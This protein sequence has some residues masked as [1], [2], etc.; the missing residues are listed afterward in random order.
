MNFQNLYEKLKR[1]DESDINQG[2]GMMAPP[3]TP[4]IEECGMSEMHGSPSQQDSVNMSVSM[5]ASGKGGIRDLM[6][7]LKNIDD[8]VSGPSDD[9]SDD[10]IIGTPEEEIEPV[11]LGEIPDPSVELDEP[12]QGEEFANEPEFQQ[13]DNIVSG[14]DLHKEKGAYPAAQKGDNG[15]AAYKKEAAIASISESLVSRLSNHYREVKSRT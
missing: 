8:A 14:N 3:S 10:V 5:N 6:D 4:A 15:I 12:L 7:I 9:D 2:T 1:I 13:F 11:N